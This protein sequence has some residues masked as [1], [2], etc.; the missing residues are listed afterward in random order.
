VHGIVLL[1][2]DEASVGV[3]AAQLDEMLSLIFNHLAT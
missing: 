1:G 2:L 3:P